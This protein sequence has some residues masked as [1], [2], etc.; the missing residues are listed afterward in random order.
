MPH[1]DEWRLTP[2]LAQSRLAAFNAWLLAQSL[3]VRAVA[4]NFNSVRNDLIILAATKER[5]LILGYED[6]G[7]EITMQVQVVDKA[8]KE[9]RVMTGVRA[10]DLSVCETNTL[11][12][13]R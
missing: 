12:K 6:I 13:V 10:G 8:G 1:A 3:P 11:G 9:L 2:T 7:P 4:Q 5:V